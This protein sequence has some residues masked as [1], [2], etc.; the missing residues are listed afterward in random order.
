MVITQLDCADGQHRAQSVTHTNCSL[1]ELN[2]AMDDIIM[3]RR[4]RNQGRTMTDVMKS[5]Q[6]GC[7]GL[8]QLCSFGRTDVIFGTCWI[9]NPSVLDVRH[10]SDGNVSDRSTPV[11]I[12]FPHSFPWKIL[13]KCLI[14]NFHWKM[15]LIRC[16]S[17]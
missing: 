6:S 8:F 15:Y 17:W 13:Q 2:A 9:C 7:W 10:E 5:Q 1:A 11:F 3:K 4:P 12:I 16:S 14:E